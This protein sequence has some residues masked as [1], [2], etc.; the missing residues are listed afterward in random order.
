MEKKRVL[1]RGISPT[2]KAWSVC[3]ELPLPEEKRGKEFYSSLEARLISRA[4]RDGLRITGR[5]VVTLEEN[6]TYSLYTE[7][8]FIYP[9]G[10]APAEVIRLCDTR[11]GGVLL[12]VPRRLK[13]RDCHG[14]C[15]I[16]GRGV[17]F[18]PRGTDG[19]T[20]IRQRDTDRYFDTV[21]TELDLN[22]FYRFCKG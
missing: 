15:I 10:T 4:E 6:K 2:G 18:L 5:T 21:S 9:D 14:F 16:E 1:R 20:V 12:P 22:A 7:F 3:A 8:I 13:R 11:L 19:R 17:A